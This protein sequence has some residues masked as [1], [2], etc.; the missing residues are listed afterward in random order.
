MSTKNLEGRRALVTGATGGIGAAIATELH[1]HGASVALSGRRQERLDAMA[2]Q[3]G[4]NCCAVPCDLQDR[5]AVA[6]LPGRAAE[7]LG[8]LDIVVNNAGMTRDGLLLRMSDQDWDKVVEVNLTAT[9]IISRQALRPM[10]KAR[11]GRIINISSVVGT[12]GNPGQVNYAAA[13][14]GMAGLTKSLA[15][16]VATRGITVNCVAPGFIET[17]MTASMTDEQRQKILGQIP[18]ARMGKPEDIADAVSFLL[19][20][21]YVTGQTLHVNGGLAMV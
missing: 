9:M 6:E 13:K 18:V 15:F 16:E 2:E 19:A 17:E 20:A 10:I 14:A 11:W 5:I 12:T 1:R 21:D 3:F 7:A 4:Q 8:G